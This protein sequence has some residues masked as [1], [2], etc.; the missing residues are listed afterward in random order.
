MIFNRERFEKADL[1]LEDIV[2]KFIRGSGRGGQKINKTSSCVQL[3]HIPSGIVVSCQATRSQS[4][5]RELALQELCRKLEEKKRREESARRHAFEK[6]RRKK[7]GR[8]F[9][10]KQEML[11]TKRKVSEKKRARRKPSMED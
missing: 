11:R 1:R 2:E 7:R 8:S 10:G 3:I 9:M 5:N 4:E 6:E